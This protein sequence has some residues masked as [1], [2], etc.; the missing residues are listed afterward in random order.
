MD[1]AKVKVSC[2]NCGTTNYFPMDAVG[3]NVVCGRCRSALPKPGTVLE[4]A[5]AQVHNLF[6][7]S[8]LPVLADFYSTTCGPCL[9]M[10]PVV[11][12]LA[13]R[14][15]GG[16]TVVRINVERHPELA[17]GFGIRGVPTFMVVLKGVERGRISG[18]Q[19]EEDFALWVAS[20]A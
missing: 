19:T 3:K 4:P 10:H 7:T 11:E 17:A 6:R 14:R 8:S 5:P 1:G 20:R 18:A 2:G 13:R 9:V 16:L 15:A 12:R